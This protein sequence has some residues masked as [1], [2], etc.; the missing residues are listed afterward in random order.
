[1]LASF[2]RELIVL[3]GACVEPIANF[4]CVCFI[5]SKFHTEQ[6][7]VFIYH[8]LQFHTKEEIHSL[9]NLQSTIGMECSVSVIFMLSLHFFKYIFDTRQPLFS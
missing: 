5:F 3:L 7:F 2:C 8:I 6:G 9:H 1:M 4:L